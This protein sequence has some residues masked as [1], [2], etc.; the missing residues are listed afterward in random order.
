MLMVSARQSHGVLLAE[1]VCLESKSERNGQQDYLAGSIQ[2]WL[3]GVLSNLALE[4]PT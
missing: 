1:V 2:P 3:D 4:V